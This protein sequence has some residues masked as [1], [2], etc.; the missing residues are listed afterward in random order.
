M[1]ALFS[2]P[3]FTCGIP[4]PFFRLAWVLA[5]SLVTP[6]GRPASSA[7]PPHSR[8]RRLAGRASDD[9]T[10]RASIVS[11]DGVETLALPWTEA[12][13]NARIRDASPR[14]PLRLRARLLTTRQSC[15]RR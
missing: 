14:R 1:S 11:A 13:V 2:V 12:G 3:T 10:G 6:T 4:D 7:A 15:G 8:G 9:W 5:A